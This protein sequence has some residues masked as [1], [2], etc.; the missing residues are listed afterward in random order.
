MAIAKC[1][2]LFQSDATRHINCQRVAV[3]TGLHP[4]RNQDRMGPFNWNLDTN[5][6][7]FFHIR[8]KLLLRVNLDMFNVL[9]RQVLNAPDES[10]IASLANSYAGS[11]FRPRQLQGTLRLEW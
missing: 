9:N 11:G 3:D 5:L 7:K 6:M 8:E 10:G 1:A 4:W 2:A